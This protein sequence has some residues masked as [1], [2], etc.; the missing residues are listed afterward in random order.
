MK[1]IKKA[2][3]DA[4]RI[5]GNRIQFNM[6]DLSKIFKAGEDAGI[7]GGDIVQ[8]VKDAIQKYRQN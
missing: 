8:A 7:A 5:H 4:F 2:V 1:K 3:E 6:M